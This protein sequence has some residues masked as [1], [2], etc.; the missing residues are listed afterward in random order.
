MSACACKFRSLTD[1]STL[2]L[3][4]LASSSSRHRPPQPQRSRSHVGHLALKSASA[5]SSPAHRGKLVFLLQQQ[6]VLLRLEVVSGHWFVRKQLLDLLARR[7]F[8]CTRIINQVSIQHGPLTSRQPTSFEFVE[9][10]HGLRVVV[11]S[12][13]DDV[14][15]RTR[16]HV[17]SLEE[18]RVEHFRLLVFDL[19][20]DL[21]ALA[22]IRQ[23]L[24]KASQLVKNVC[25][26]ATTVARLAALRREGRR[27]PRTVLLHKQ[28]KQNNWYLVLP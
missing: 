11:A 14:D 12:D 24:L 27:R 28:T 8:S 3:E 7:R 15:V 26:A 1:K 10:L 20:F 16:L 9:V 17:R 21:D 6:R 25:T 2:R 19:E 13:I 18:A 22:F 4:E 23:L 5:R